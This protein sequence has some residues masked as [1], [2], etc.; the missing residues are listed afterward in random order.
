VTSSRATARRAGRSRWL[1]AGLLVFVVPFT[2]CS[3]DSST[4]P[5]PTGVSIA[6]SSAAPRSEAASPSASES[7]P[8]ATD[9]PTDD[10]SSAPATAVSTAVA[11]V[12]V[13]EKA[14]ADSAVVEVSSDDDDGRLIWEIIVRVGDD[15]R[16]L[17]I[18]GSDGAVLSNQSDRLD[19][20]QLG[21]LPT[22]TVSEA[23]EIA[24]KQVPDGEVTDAELSRR[25]GERVWDVS[26]DVASGEDW[27]LWIDA[28]SG[29]VLREERD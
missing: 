4:G 29:E 17:R 19:Q 2:S 9:A 26:V 21:D 3:D 28:A 24:E 12:A 20:S 13:A 15:G 22:V 11:A 25:N 6:P 27:E 8:S 16:E 7:S 5:E 10:S 18:D 1:A 23:I 14:V